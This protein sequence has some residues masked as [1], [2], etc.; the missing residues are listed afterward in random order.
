MIDPV[1][2][3]AAGSAA[4]SA[5]KKG[6]QIGRDIESMASDIG[7][8]MNAMSDITEAEKQA[9]NP[10]IFK[11]LAFSGSVEAE[12]MEAFARKTKMENQRA[13]LKQWISMSLGPSKWE[14]LIRMEG[15]IRKERQD[16]IYKQAQKRRK[17][18]EWVTIIFLIILFS[19]VLCGIIWLLMQYGK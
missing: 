1:S 13:E 16:T 7:R 14:E 4:F 8:W 18:M 12:A 5:I 10:P 17:F 3:M 19:G 2:A 6:V 11:K 9:K 15:Q